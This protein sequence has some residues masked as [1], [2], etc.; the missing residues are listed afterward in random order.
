M[1]TNFF[2]LCLFLA[3]LLCSS[4]IGGPKVDPPG[5]TNEGS[6]GFSGP[7]TTAR[8]GTSAEGEAMDSGTAPPPTTGT[9]GGAGGR[10]AE[11]DA[12]KESDAGL[13]DDDDSGSTYEP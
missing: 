1:L 6:A 8:A 12:V 2:R 7:Y 13:V 4:C 11:D 10:G 9:S 3:F 5:A